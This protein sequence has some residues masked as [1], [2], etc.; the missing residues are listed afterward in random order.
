[1]MMAPVHWTSRSALQSWA[2]LPLSW[3]Y[4]LLLLL[5]MAMVKPTLLEVPVI[6][7]G[8]NTV[9]GAGKTPTVIALCHWLTAMGKKPHVIS[10]GYGGHYTDSVLQVDPSTHTAT[11]VGDEPLLIAQHAPCWVARRRKLA[12]RS[13]IAAGA[14]VIVMDDGLQNP[15]IVKDFSILV[16]D[17]DYGFGN[18]FMMPAGPCREPVR[19]SMSKADA[20]L[21][22]GEERNPSIRRAIPASK[23]VFGAALIPSADLSLQG[24]PVYAFAGIGYPDKF[25]NTLKKMG[26]A[27]VGSERFPDHHPY[28]LA[29]LERLARESENVRARLVTTEKDFVRIPALYH[30]LITPIPVTLDL[31][32][33]DAFISLLNQQVVS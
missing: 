31:N 15:S 4:R 22:I 23:P 19:I 24:V 18:R 11:Q 8:N 6:C 1:M 2:L 32:Q 3:L 21:I 20:V 10:R 33:K 25:F 12:A 7:V 27:V 17:G 13:A 9:G 16:V 29:D 30:N 28:G 14:N 26:A 5:R